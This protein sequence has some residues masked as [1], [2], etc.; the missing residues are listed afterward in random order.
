M[1]PIE[2]PTRL[3][4]IVISNSPISVLLVED[5]EIL[6]M[7]IRASIANDLGISV[8][9]EAENGQ[10]AIE[11]FETLRPDV[12]LMDINMPILDGIKSSRAIKELS[13][14]TK[15]IMLTSSEQENDVYSALSSGASGYCLK[16]IETDRLCEAIKA[17]FRGD[18]WLDAGIADKVLRLC[19][20]DNPAQ[21]ITC[22]PVSFTESEKQLLTQM[23]IG[24]SPNH[25]AQDM[26]VSPSFA[27]TRIINVLKKVELATMSVDSSS[28]SLND[29][30]R[31]DGL[32]EKY[33]FLG[34]LGRGGMSFV[35]KARHKLLN[36]LFAIKF[37]GLHLVD[38]RSF[39]ARFTREAQTMSELCHPN[40]V[41]IHDFGFSMDGQPYIIMDYADGPTLS[42]VLE[43]CGSMA[44]AEAGELFLQITDALAYAHQREL[45]HR[46]VKP[47][48]IIVCENNGR[49]TA[50]LL[51]F[52]LALNNTDEGIS[53]RLTQTGQVLGSPVY[54]SP[55]QCRADRVDA[56]SDVYS[57]GCLMFEC[58]S[59]RPPFYGANAIETMAMHLS[60]DAPELDHNIYPS[61]L[62]EIISTCL[63]KDPNERFTHAGALHLALRESY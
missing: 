44:P 43:R 6:R 59:G 17:V 48:N 54:M 9:G 23:L 14:N 24:A 56:R 57:L 49:T 13:R 37:L 55:E 16:D 25:I 21:R 50:K 42:E 53:Q 52:G 39:T 46:D 36:K 40:I 51:D 26:H 27:R 8:V 31:S 34:V 3:E 4:N 10:T 61:S 63:Q 62:C 20:R 15:I 12:V 30:A 22:E 7:G 11:K 19:S 29:Q 33:E 38:S 45:V 60:A 28:E 32:M 2:A 1:E 58:L 18:V 47:A 35:Y 41:A 5:Q